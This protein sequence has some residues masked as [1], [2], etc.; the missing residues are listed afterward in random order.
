MRFKSQFLLSISV[1][2]LTACGGGSSAP[3]PKTDAPLPPISSTEAAPAPLAETDT[4]TPV[5]PTATSPLATPATTTTIVTTEPAVVV[6]AAPATGSSVEE[7]IA[8]LEATVGSLRSDYDRIMPAFA[9]LNTTNERIQTL[10]DEIEKETGKPVAAQAVKE[11]PVTTTE[12]TTSTT[13][14]TPMA[15]SASTPV[16]ETETVKTET[17][18]TET[19]AAADMAPSTKEGGNNISGVRIGEHGSKTRL[20]LDLTSKTKPA[21]K[22]DLDNNEKL[23]LVDLPDSG[24]TGAA[25]AK[26]NSPMIASWNVQK[27]PNGGSTLAIQL[28]GSAR[29]LSTEFL[30]A[31]GKDPARLVMDIASGG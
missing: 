9:S 24:W 16:L 20:V 1:L 25:S 27:G 21:F 26:P 22:Y 18:K 3:S 17:V 7:R 30:K 23:L 2:A 11:T 4:L 13:T 8:K 12:T 14:V 31:E 6:P 10:L 19:V 5:M 28:K 15:S 29:V